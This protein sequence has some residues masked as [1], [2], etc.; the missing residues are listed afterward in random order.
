M[1]QNAPH[2]HIFETQGH[3]GGG[4]EALPDENGGPRNPRKSLR[5][6]L[7]KNAI[8][9]N[10]PH[11]LENYLEVGVTFQNSICSIITASNY[12]SQVGGV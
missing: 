2:G 11:A 3:R 10:V 5:F 4:L 6:L 12:F 8:T 1:C 9:K 7:Q